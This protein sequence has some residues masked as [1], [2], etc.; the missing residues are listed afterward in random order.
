MISS[1]TKHASTIVDFTSCRLGFYTHTQPGRLTRTQFPSNCQGTSTSLRRH[2]RN[3]G[4]GSTFGELVA[5]KKWGY[6]G[7][8]LSVIPSVILPVH[9]NVVFAQYIE[10]K[11]IVFH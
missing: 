7:F 3:K 11:L 6:T 5:L 8:G 1:G 10:N 4:R 2:D 9:Q